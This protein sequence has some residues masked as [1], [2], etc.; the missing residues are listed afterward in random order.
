M[1]QIDI[2][3]PTLSPTMEAATLVRWRVGRGDR[4]AFGAVLAEIETDKAT[5]EIE[6]EG[7]G[8]LAEILVPDGSEGVKVNTPIGR[9]SPGPLNAQSSYEAKGQPSAGDQKPEG[10]DLG[11]SASPLDVAASPEGQ[12]NTL[13]PTPVPAQPPRA[14]DVRATALARSLAE[15]QGIDLSMVKGSG[16]QGKILKVDLAAIRPLARARSVV[17]VD[18]APAVTTT[19]PPAPHAD[20]NGAYDLAP[21]SST[22]R[23][24]AEHLSKSFREVPHFPLTIDIGLEGLMP[25]LDR[26]NDGL[27]GSGVTVGVP[28]MI[29]KAIAA[30]LRRT[31]EANASY[32]PQGL[33]LHHEASIAVSIA[34]PGGTLAPVLRNAGVKGV[35]QIARELRE[36]TRRALCGDLR[37]EELVGGSF[38]LIDLG[39]FGVRSFSTVLAA[40]HACALA[41]GVANQRAVVRGDAI[42]I[43]TVMTVT[44]TCDH[45]AVDGAIGARFL[46][47][48]RA[49]IEDP[50][51]LII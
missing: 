50:L 12:S 37:D 36:L 17:L 20:A 40:P 19:S 8:F 6:A 7:E 5:M 47:A 38:S 32:T 49:G 46:Q 42:A 30:A 23:E 14:A 31:P 45:R 3:M 15:G 34:A 29:I 44:L 43:A 41:V 9:L 25:V 39:A 28:E 16:P 26:I 48:L 11:A 13:D 27:T 18:V 21:A 33:I 24:T 35:A 2:L 10:S 1:T 22:W 4:V 51:A